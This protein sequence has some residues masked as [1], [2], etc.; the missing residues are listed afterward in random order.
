MTTL[1]LILLRMRNVAD[2]LCRE[3][4]HILCSII[5]FRTSCNVEG[6]V[7]KTGRARHA[8]DYIRR[9]MHLAY[10]MTKDTDTHSEYVT[11]IAF[12]WNSGYAKEL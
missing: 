3:N 5:F 10:C 8:T 6:N 11:L 7:K 9:R 12:P 1:N 2:K 4:T